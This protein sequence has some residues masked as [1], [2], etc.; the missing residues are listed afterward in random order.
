MASSKATGLWFFVTVAL[1]NEYGWVGLYIQLNS[2]NVLEAV[3]FHKIMSILTRT[4]EGAFL[5][6]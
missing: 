6:T 1:G 2:V 3:Q 5:F 4:P